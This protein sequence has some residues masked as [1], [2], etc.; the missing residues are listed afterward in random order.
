LP[1]CCCQPAVAGGVVYAD[2]WGEL[3]THLAPQALFVQSSPVW[4]PLLQAFPFPSTGK[5][6]TAPTLSGL[7]VYLH[8]MWEVGLPP[9]PVKFS[10][11]CH[12]HKLSC[13]CLLG[14]AAA[15][16]SCHVCL[17]FR[18]EVGL[19]SSPVEFSSLRHSHKLPCFWLL[20]MRPAPA[21]T[22]ASPA[23]PA[24][25]FTV[26]LQSWEGFPSPNLQCSGRPTLFPACLYCS[27]CL[28][29]SFSFFP[30]WRSVCPGGYAALAQACLW[31]YRGTVK[32]TWSA[33]SQAVGRR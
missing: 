1:A 18:W 31:E 24:C 17:Q 21:P 33:S 9:S 13:S 16:A 25:L 32:L 19:P 7:C 26:Y 10:S 8:F 5:G 14:G 29:L 2:L 23:H 4:E 22:R 20:G 6:D 28:L 15:P 27:Y 30:R 11:H 12:L 3:S